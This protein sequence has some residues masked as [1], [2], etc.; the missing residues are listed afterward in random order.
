M[1]W[2]AQPG[3]V[4]CKPAARTPRSNRAAAHSLTVAPT[5]LGDPA[6]QGGDLRTVLCG[7]APPEWATSG[8]QIA[9]DI[10]EALVFL[11]SHNVTHRCEAAGSG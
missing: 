5:P 8:R 9:L 11:H 4:S 6:P 3:L 2:K 7:H 1:H 10:A